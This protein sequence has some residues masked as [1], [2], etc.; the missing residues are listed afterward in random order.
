MIG[1][2][3]VSDPAKRFRRLCEAVSSQIIGGS[4]SDHCIADVVG[5]SIEFVRRQRK[6]LSS[7][8]PVLPQQLTR[9]VF[10]KK[11]TGKFMKK[12]TKR[13]EV[14]TKSMKKLKEWIAENP[15]G[16]LQKSFHQIAK[17]ADVSQ[18]VVS[19]NLKRIIAQREGITTDEVA[20]RRKAAGFSKG[21]KQTVPTRPLLPTVVET[22]NP[23]SQSLKLPVAD[24]PV[25]RVSQPHDSDE[26]KV[27]S[28]HF[29]KDIYRQLAHLAIDR[30]CSIQVLMVEALNLL[31]EQ[32]GLPRF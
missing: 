7:R 10:D 8:P 31:F 12:E 32:E 19:Y 25:K 26:R 23:E 14:E 13:K 20:A 27:I 4:L 5:T 3:R 18:N 30:D 29:D 21:G 24:F 15:D 16:Y 11:F 22:P 28:G 9:G 6:F 2:I 17:D 1:M